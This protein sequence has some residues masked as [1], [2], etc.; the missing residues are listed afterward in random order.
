MILFAC[1]APVQSIELLLQ[2]IVE[3]SRSAFDSGLEEDAAAWVRD[4]LIR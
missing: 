3:E 2:V 1:S 4:H